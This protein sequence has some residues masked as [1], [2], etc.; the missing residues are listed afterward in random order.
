[1]IF[2]SDQFFMCSSRDMASASVLSRPDMYLM[3]WRSENLMSWTMTH[4]IA[5]CP[6]PPNLSLFPLPIFLKKFPKMT[7]S[8]TPEPQLNAGTIALPLKSG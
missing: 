3:V 8:G 2:G 6:P 5:L 1:M 7:L 4:K